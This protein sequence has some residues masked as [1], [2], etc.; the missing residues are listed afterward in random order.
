M[1]EQGDWIH[2]CLPYVTSLP[3]MP[4]PEQL[5]SPPGSMTDRNMWE[6]RDMEGKSWIKDK[7]WK[8]VWKP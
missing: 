7:S 4:D 6:R 2:L 1:E 5:L 8:E 3:G